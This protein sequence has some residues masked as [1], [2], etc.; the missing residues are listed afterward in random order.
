MTSKLTCWPKV[1]LQNFDDSQLSTVVRFSWF[2]RRLLMTDLIIVFLDSDS[3][4]E[5][6]FSIQGGIWFFN[7][8]R[9][10]N[11]WKSK[12]QTFKI[13]ILLLTLNHDLNKFLTQIGILN[14]YLTTFDFSHFEYIFKNFFGTPTLLYLYNHH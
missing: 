12:I 14:S 2:L 6:D 8:R 13:P 11:P 4:S 7:S 5:L 1:E 9:N 10:L 3:K